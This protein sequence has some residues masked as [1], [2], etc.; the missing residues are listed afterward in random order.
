MCCSAKSSATS[1]DRFWDFAASELLR[2]PNCRNFVADRDS[3]AVE[4]ASAHKGTDDRIQAV[5]ECLYLPALRIGTGDGEHLGRT[6]DKAVEDGDNPAPDVDQTVAA[7]HCQARTAILAPEGGA[8]LTKNNFPS[9]SMRR[10]IMSA[11]KDDASRRGR[12]KKRGAHSN[13]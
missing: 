6:G 9:T 3:L 8:C 10:R 7:P 11:I 5:L 2:D 12:S 1:S 4:S 13:S